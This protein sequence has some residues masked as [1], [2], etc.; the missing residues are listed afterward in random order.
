MNFKVRNAL[1]AL[2]LAGLAACTPND[3]TMG[4]ALRH[5]I[6][7]QVVDPDPEAKTALVEGGDGTRSAAAAE[8]YQKGQVKEPVVQTTTS[9]SG[10]SG[11]GSGP[12]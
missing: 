7:H 5:N 4:G 11:G 2:A 3:T 10:G 9:G 12:R 1:G 6:A 8:K